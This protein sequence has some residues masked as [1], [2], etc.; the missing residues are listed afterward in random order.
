MFVVI[1]GEVGQINVTQSEK[2][3]LVVEKRKILLPPNY[4]R[5][6][7]WGYIDHSARIILLEGDKVNTLTQSTITL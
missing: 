6:F 2:Q 3:L 1:R 4:T 7:A 5:Y